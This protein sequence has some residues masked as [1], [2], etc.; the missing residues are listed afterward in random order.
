LSLIY[1]NLNNNKH[2]VQVYSMSYLRL[3][4]VKV[5]RLVVSILIHV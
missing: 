1:I 5:N 4:Y 2:I 3:C